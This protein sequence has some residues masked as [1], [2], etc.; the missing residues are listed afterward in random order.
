MVAQWQA[1]SCATGTSVRC[2]EKRIIYANETEERKPIKKRVTVEDK[3]PGGESVIRVLSSGGGERQHRVIPEG[4]SQTVDFSVPL[5]G[6]IEI[7]C[8]GQTG[9]D[10]PFTV[11]PAQ[12]NG[13][14]TCGERRIIYTNEVDDIKPIKVSVTVTSNCP[15]GESIIRVLSSGGGERQHRVIP[16]GGSQTVDFSVPLKGSIEIEC[17]GQMGQGCSFSIN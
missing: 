1:I 6:S 10:C 11:A 16:E 15:G 5:K 12:V 8:N 3:C 4:G 17:N 9:E 13:S 7:E 2:G 14:L